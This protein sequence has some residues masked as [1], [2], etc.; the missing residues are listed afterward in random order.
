M[1]NTKKIPMLQLKIYT[2][3]RTLQF[4]ETFASL[5]AAFAS[6]G[7]R[8]AQRHQLAFLRQAE[9]YKEGDTKRS[10]CVWMGM[11]LCSAWLNPGTALGGGFF[12]FEQSV[13]SLGNAFA[14]A[15]SSAEDASTIFYNAA[16]I[17]QLPGSQFE[18]GANVVVPTAKFDNHGSTTSPAFPRAARRCSADRRERR[19]RRQSG[20]CTQFLFSPGD[21]TPHSRRSRGQRPLGSGNQLQP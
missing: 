18:L 5:T 1:E 2:E 8:A 20:R 13:K 9:R 10:T 12:L 21:H 16:G 7:N 15:E 3:P 14:G 6:L 11:L 4:L 19:R 17:T